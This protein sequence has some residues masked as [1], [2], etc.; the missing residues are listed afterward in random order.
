MTFS[1]D[2]EKNQTEK[3][4]KK[5]ANSL[6]IQWF[7]GSYNKRL[8]IAKGNNS[9]NKPQTTTTLSNIAINMTLTVIETPISN[10]PTNYFLYNINERKVWLVGWLADWLHLP[11]IMVGVVF[12]TQVIRNKKKKKNFYTTLLAVFFFFFC[13]SYSSCFFT[14]QLKT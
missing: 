4:Q 10:I 6:Q 2:E 11:D 13:K 14:G 1:K 7:N 3:I 12:K 5:M 9:N 8:L